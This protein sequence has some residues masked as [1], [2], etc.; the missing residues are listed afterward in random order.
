MD[1]LQPI[2]MVEA[3]IVLQKLTIV[4]TNNYTLVKKNLPLQ[5]QTLHR[6]S[7]QEVELTLANISKLKLSCKESEW[8]QV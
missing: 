3:I 4:N 7:R 8:K 2:E 1:F 6:S 5:F